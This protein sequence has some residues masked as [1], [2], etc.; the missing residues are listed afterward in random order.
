MAAPTSRI[1]HASLVSPDEV[2]VY[3]D[4]ALK[5]T[6]W[7]LRTGA[8]V[9]IRDPKITSRIVAGYDIRPTTNHLAMLA[10]TGAKDMVVVF[11]PGKR[12][13][14]ST[15]TADTI[16]AKGIKWSPDGLWLVVWES[17]SMGIGVFVYT[18]DGQLFRRWEGQIQGADD[19]GA[20][21]E[22]IGVGVERCEWSANGDLWV[23]TGNGK[24]VL[25]AAKKVWVVL[26]LD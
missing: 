13:V 20:H 25:L 17:G 3:T 23:A 8:G 21:I 6:I 12:E 16:D 14:E 15:W 2:L 10:R 5:A 24:V 26:A 19:D 4:F 11:S 7:D 1:A 9:E 18:A 22:D